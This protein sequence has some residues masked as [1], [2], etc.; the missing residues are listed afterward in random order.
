MLSASL[1]VGPAMDRQI[2]RDLFGHTL[3]RAG[4]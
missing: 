2:I 3:A 4:A 1:C